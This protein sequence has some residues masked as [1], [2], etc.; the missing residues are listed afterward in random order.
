MAS[1]RTI[2]AQLK[3]S[4]Y[5]Y[6]F[7]RPNAP[8]VVRANDFAF[9]ENLLRDWSPNYDFSAELPHIKAALAGDH[10]NAAI[11][12]YLTFGMPNPLE[13]PPQPALY[14]HGI[15]DGCLDVALMNDVLDYLPNPKSRMEHIAAAGHFP[16]LE[17]SDEVAKIVLDFLASSSAPRSA[18]APARA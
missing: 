8:D 18:N 13:P 10:A 4:W 2:Y 3:R 17:R 7:H 5:I 16:Q 15:D 9:I 11:A 6:F 1:K 14:L 12:Y